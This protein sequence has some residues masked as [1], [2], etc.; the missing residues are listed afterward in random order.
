[1][2]FSQFPNVLDR[3]SD[4]IKLAVTRIVGSSLLDI[5]YDDVPI[6]QALQRGAAFPELASDCYCRQRP[7][8]HQI[9]WRTGQKTAVTGA[10]WETFWFHC[11]IAGR[12]F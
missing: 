10:N 6:T 2:P 4:V 12:F 1:V 5:H 7:C 3:S 8:W 9:A 11:G